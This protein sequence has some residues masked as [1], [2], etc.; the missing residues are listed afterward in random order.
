MKRKNIKYIF[1]S[2]IFIAIVFLLINVV[3]YDVDYKKDYN[4]K[5]PEQAKLYNTKETLGSAYLIK[6]GNK[7]IVYLDYAIGN[8]ISKPK[9]ISISTKGKIITV[10]VKKPINNGLTMINPH[11]FK[12]AVKG[13]Y[14]SVILKE[15]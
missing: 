13:N 10:K 6:D 12:I 15:I 4:F 3:K 8:S 9:I 14:N 2:V 5:I 11:Y 7:T 1:A